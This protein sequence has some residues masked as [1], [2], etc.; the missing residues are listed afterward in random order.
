MKAFLNEN[1]SKLFYIA[2][3]GDKVEIFPF[4]FKKNIF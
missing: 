4:F 3:S 2:F 1:R